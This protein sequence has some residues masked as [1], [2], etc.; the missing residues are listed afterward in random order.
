MLVELSIKHMDIKPLSEI[1]KKIGK[2]L[3]ESCGLNYENTEMLYHKI[4][5]YYARCMDELSVGGSIFVERA[6]PDE[7]R[8]IKSLF[9]QLGKLIVA[10]DD[11]TPAAREIAEMTLQN[12]E[13]DSKA[14][15]KGIRPFACHELVEAFSPLKRV[16]ERFSANR[17]SKRGRP[18]LRSIS[19]PAM[20]FCS[21]W[22]EI[23]GKA[24]SWNDKGTT[25][26]FE[27]HRL[28]SKQFELVIAMQVSSDVRS[29]LKVTETKF[30]HFRSAAGQALRD[31]VREMRRAN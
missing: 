26:L 24:P 4:I 18:K 27:F 12:P 25:G 7:Y 15:L 13:L 10:Y 11:L 16:H 21:E 3:Q 6:R 8:A 22:E 9:K 20:H 5:F 1:N 19:K 14:K 29:D 30:S 31:A 28:A 17:G 2:A 23:T